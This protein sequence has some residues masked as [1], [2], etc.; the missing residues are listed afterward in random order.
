VTRDEFEKNLAA[1]IKVRALTEDLRP[2]LTTGVQYDAGEA[3]V[4]VA[5]RLLALL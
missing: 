5:D 2:L 4:L 1:K 3:A